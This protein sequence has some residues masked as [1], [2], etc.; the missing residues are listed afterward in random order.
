MIQHYKTRL[1][2][3]FLQI[4][5]KSASTLIF[6]N[7]LWKNV[8]VSIQKWLG[9][10][11]RVLSLGWS[12]FPVS[13]SEINQRLILC[14]SIF[15]FVIHGKNMS[16]NFYVLCRFEPVTFDSAFQLARFAPIA[17]CSIKMNLT[18][19]LFISFN[20]QIINFFLR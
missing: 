19:L 3:I 12:R 5:L 11:F 1:F 7:A 15:K 8:K 2:L 18:S 10:K 13:G 4:N 20:R 6:I 17:L 14:S 9:G 16:L